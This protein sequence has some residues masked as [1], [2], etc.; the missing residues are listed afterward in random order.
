MNDF[1]KQLKDGILTGSAL[2]TEAAGSQIAKHL[3]VDCVLALHGDLG[4]GKTTLIRGLAR[5]WGIKEAVT[6]PTYN[7]YS[8]YQGARQ[9]IHLDAYRLH[10][11]SELDSL[12]I[13][14]FLR[15]P[16]CLAVEWPENIKESIPEDAWHLHLSIISEE[17]HCIQL[18]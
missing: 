9:L 4:V 15:P 5:A 10:T 1:I 12:M 16:W 18:R 8:I 6:S 11:S 17:T 2:E 7:L 3:P 14:D 13:E